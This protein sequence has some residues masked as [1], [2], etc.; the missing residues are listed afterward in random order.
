MLRRKRVGRVREL[1][2]RAERSGESSIDDRLDLE[3]LLRGLEPSERE[4]LGLRYVVQMSSME[5]GQQLGLSAEGVRSR[6]HRLLER[7]R[8]DLRDG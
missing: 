1:E 8:K 3:Q 6:L 5:I 7:L 4:L 2:A